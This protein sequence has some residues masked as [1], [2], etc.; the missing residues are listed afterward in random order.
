MRHLKV[1]T[2]LFVLFVV[3]ACNSQRRPSPETLGRTHQELLV[4]G[5]PCTQNSHCDSG[6][7]VDAVCCENACG[8]GARDTF[9]CSNVYGTVAGL[10]DGKCTQL[11]VGEA[12]GALESFDPCTWRGTN[13]N[14]GHNCPNPPFGSQEFSC[15][16]CSAGQTC[17]DG[18]P[19]CVGGQCLGCNGDFSS[20]ATR[21]CPTQ[22]SPA[23]VAGACLECSATNLTACT[24]AKPICSNNVCVPAARRLHHQLAAVV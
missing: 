14:G 12:C 21:A 20:G 17:P 23:C 4:E 13:L 15:Y 10:V 1:L 7:C 8:N 24:P 3:A 22:V 16:D 5:S 6:F 18:V 2:V 11:K 9:S 19:V